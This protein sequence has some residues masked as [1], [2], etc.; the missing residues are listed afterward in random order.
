MEEW[1]GTP[2]GYSNK[3]CRCDKCRVAWNEYCRAR[4]AAR[5]PANA[6]HGTATGYQNHG[7]RCAEC[8]A[9]NTDVYRRIEYGLPLGAYQAQYDAQGGKCALC[10]AWYSL[11]HVDH[12]HATGSVRGLLCVGC[13]SALGKLG[14]DIAGIYRA[15]EYVT[16]PPLAHLELE[17]HSNSNDGRTRWPKNE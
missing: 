1:H 13:N 8:R 3:K 10:R 5:N 6:P 14:D 15:L 2:N 11:L 9:A 16:R 17:E 7:C 4:K 12:D